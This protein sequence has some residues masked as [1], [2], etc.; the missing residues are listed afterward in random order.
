ML[1]SELTEFGGGTRPGILSF[2]SDETPY[3]GFDNSICVDLPPMSA[4]YL[5]SPKTNTRRTQQ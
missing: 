1:N 4:I 2:K 5:E 3:N